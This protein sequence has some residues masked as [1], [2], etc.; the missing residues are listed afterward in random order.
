[1][2]VREHVDASG[3]CKLMQDEEQVDAIGCKWM[4]F[5][6]PGRCKL[7]MQVEEQVDVSGRCKWMQV[8]DASGCKMKSKCE[9]RKMQVEDAG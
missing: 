5:S 9:H 1:M 8:G 2:Q 3:G 6:S 4:H 7:E